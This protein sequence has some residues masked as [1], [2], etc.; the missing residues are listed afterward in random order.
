MGGRDQL[1]EK[2]MVETRRI[3]SF[4]IHVERA[5]KSIKNYHFFDKPIPASLACVTDQAFF[6]CVVLTNFTL[7]LYN[8]LTDTNSLLL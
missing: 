8:T 5:N 6:V 4:R 3:A 7:P 1:D 2:D